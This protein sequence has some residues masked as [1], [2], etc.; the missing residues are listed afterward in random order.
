MSNLQQDFARSRFDTQQINLDRFNLFFPEK[1]PFLP[2]ERRLFSVGVG[3]EAEVFFSRAWHIGPDDRAIPI[4][5]GARLSGRVSPR[6]SVASSTE[7]DEQF[8]RGIPANNFSVAAGSAGAA[9]PV[10][11]APSS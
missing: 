11:A 9:E 3:G 4:V 10:G 5:G 8:E 7:T 6:T 2:R 1:R